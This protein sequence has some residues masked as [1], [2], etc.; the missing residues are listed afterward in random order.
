MNAKL[1]LALL[2]LMAL[3]AVTPAR[4]Q[5]LGGGG[6]IQGT[7]KDPTGGVLRAATV[8]LSNPVSGLRR[9]TTTDEMGR[10][11]FR[12]LPPN[13]YHVTVAVQG[14]QTLA[15]DLDVRSA[16]PITLELTPNLAATTQSV[17]VIGTVDLLEA[18]PSAHTDVDQSLVENCRSK[19]SAD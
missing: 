14:F 19:R 15:R 5:E 2:I 18:N 12:N 6:T 10:F 8:T 7:I 4:A 3:A 13:P 9:E 11:T 16:V 17:E 1:I